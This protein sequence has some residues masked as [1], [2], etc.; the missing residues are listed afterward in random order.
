V[1]GACLLIACFGTFFVAGRVGNF[2]NSPEGRGLFSSAASLVEAQAAVT[3]FYTDLRT[4][5]YEGAYGQLGGDLAG[6]Y[7]ASTLEQETQGVSNLSIGPSKIT[8]LPRSND[9][10]TSADLVQTIN[11]GNGKQFDT[12]LTLEKQ[13]DDTWKIVDAN[14]GLL[15]ANQ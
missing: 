8:S 6:R 7:S 12:T 2:L 13:S 5:N 9:T 15:P 4:G 10:G 14:P 1:V 3:S 11:Y